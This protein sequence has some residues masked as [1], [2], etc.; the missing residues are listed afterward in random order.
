MLAS[1]IERWKERDPKYKA[2]KERLLKIALLKEEEKE[3]ITIGQDKDFQPDAN[4]VNR[5]TTLARNQ[6]LFGTPSH[7]FRDDQ[8]IK[9]ASESG[10]DLAKTYQAKKRYEQ[11]LTRADQTPDWYQLQFLAAYHFY[12]VMI[13]LY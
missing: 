6:A 9:V 11:E 10:L 12:W 7:L 8:F 13:A 1:L 2:E 3:L 4:Y 5:L